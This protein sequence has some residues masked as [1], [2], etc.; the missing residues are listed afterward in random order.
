MII[1]IVAISSNWNKRKINN[2]WFFCSWEPQ[3]G[4]PILY[5]NKLYM[6]KESDIV[7][8]VRVIHNLIRRSYHILEVWNCLKNLMWLSSFVRRRLMI[9]LNTK[10][11]EW[12]NFQHWFNLVL[13]YGGWQRS[14]IDVF[15]RHSSFFTFIITVKTSSFFHNTNIISKT[16]KELIVTYSNNLL[17]NMKILLLHWKDL[18]R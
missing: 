7:I 2:L 9:W 15:N 8:A 16:R 4:I 6:A 18:M 13:R 14:W 17:Q 1:T 5:Q 3:N 12:K 11:R 10:K